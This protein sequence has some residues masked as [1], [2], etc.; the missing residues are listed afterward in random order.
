MDQVHARA[1]AANRRFHR[2]D[3]TPGGL[4]ARLAAGILLAATALA[5]C[6]DPCDK[7]ERKV[8]VELDDDR[9][10]KLMQDSWRRDRLSDETCKGILDA[11]RED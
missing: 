4:R 7:L 11:L 2:P 6:D 10:C 5:G 1:D 8:C 3:R 9:R